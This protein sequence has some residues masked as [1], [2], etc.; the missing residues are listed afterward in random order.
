MIYISGKI[1]GTSDYIERFAEAEKRLKKCGEEV[2]NPAKTCATLPPSLSWQDYMAVAI[3][4]LER[5]DTIYMMAG[6]EDSKGAVL[7]HEKAEELGKLII[8]EAQPTTSFVEI[9]K[10][11]FGCAEACAEA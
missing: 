9:Y 3:T 11:H 2:I 1:T 6:W 7:E 4:L 8:Y 10:R 5:C